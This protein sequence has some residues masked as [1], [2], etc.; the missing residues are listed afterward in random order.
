V[1]AVGCVVAVLVAGG[2]VMLGMIVGDDPPLPPRPADLLSDPFLLR[3][4]ADSVEVVWFTGS[5]GARHEVLV[6]EGAADGP[7]GTWRVVPATTIELSRTA[8]DRGSA[9]PGRSWDRLTRRP[10]WRH[11]AVVDGLEPGVR[12]PYR[13][14]STDG[15]EVGTSGQFTLGPAPAP[16]TPL[17]ILLTSDHQQMPMTAANLDRVVARVGR[18]DAVFV[19]GDLVNIPD[20]AS[21]WFD[22]VRGGFFPLLQGRGDQEAA[23]RRYRGAEI[24]QHAPLYPAVG[25]HE[26]MGRTDAGDLGEQFDAAVPREVAARAWA[27]RGSEASAD[28]DDRMRW[29]VEQSFNTITYDEIFGVAG[30]G[31]SGGRYYAATIGDVRLVALYAT[32]IWRAKTVEAGDRRSAFVER[33][34]DLGDELAQGWGQHIFEPIERGSEQYEW[35]RAEVASEEFRSARY[36]V[37]MLHHPIHSLGDNASPSF[38]DPVR[39]EE[40]NGDGRLRGVRY[41][42]PAAANHLVRD[43]EPLLAEAGVDLVLNG[44]SHLWNRFRG[45]GGVV[46]LETSNVGNS[47]GAFTDT[48]AARF[49]PPDPWDPDDASATGD[50]AGLEPAVPNGRPLLGE[51]GSP[52]PFVA[53][54]EV[55]VFSILDT[56]DG[57]VTSYAFDT[58]KPDDGT[59]VLDRVELGR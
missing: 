6:G 27:D 14:R 36:R 4:T 41:E 58:T 17:R 38:T 45:P 2:A 15:G 23:G 7:P 42:Y 34:D 51:D 28:P 35:L 48:T 53:S 5:P 22:S 44:H 26:V 49:V 3:P 52:M 30:D 55:T 10:V 1:L 56:G 11:M 40:R 9:V 25:N 46:H 19:A 16:A 32:Q 31:P 33:P 47:Y 29:I 8:E 24:I 54:N 13:V 39:V 59:W 50:P 43:V 37:V 20:R 12:L 21:E 18:P 57:S